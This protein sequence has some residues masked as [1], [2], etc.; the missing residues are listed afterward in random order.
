MQNDLNKN[1]LF[2]LNKIDLKIEIQGSTFKLKL[3]LYRLVK[4]TLDY[5]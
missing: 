4:S 2:E 3:V 1:K 5:F